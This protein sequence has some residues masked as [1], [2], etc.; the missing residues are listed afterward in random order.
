MYLPLG[1]LALLLQ[2]GGFASLSCRRGLRFPLGALA[3]L[4]IQFGQA[5]AS[6]LSA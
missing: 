2:C 1:L 6:T 5:A 3:F 4:R